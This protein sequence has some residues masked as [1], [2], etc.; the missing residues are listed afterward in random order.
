MWIVSPDQ[1]TQLRPPQG[2]RKLS[3]AGKALQGA[4]HFKELL[5]VSLSCTLTK[6]LKATLFIAQ[7]ILLIGN[8]MNGA[9]IK[10]GAFGFRVSSI[11]KVCIRRVPTDRY[12][13]GR[14]SSLSTRNLFT[15]LLCFISLR[16]LCLS[17]SLIWKNSCKSL[18]NLL[19]LTG[20]CV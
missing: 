19:K 17:I 9:G 6:K 20:V 7:F 11:N 14:I 10:G 18:A 1:P 3:E 12:I 8:Y 16:E 15:T 13:Y 4:I 5:S 2:A